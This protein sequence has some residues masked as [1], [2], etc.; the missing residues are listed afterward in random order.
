MKKYI[1]ILGAIF[2]VS[3]LASAICAADL[4]DNEVPGLNV[5]TDF[6]S[7]CNL[8]QNQN[9]SLVIIFDQD[10]CM[11]CD[12]FKNDVLSNA[13]IQKELNENFIVV[14]VDINKNPDI[15]NRYKIL[16]T[17]TVQFVKSNGDNATKIDGYVDSDEFLKA[18]KEI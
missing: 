13:S 17:P 7:A 11:Y 10:S 2:L 9:K 6:D 16:G 12:M 14:L 1:L 15:A 8:S 4:G 18:I 5:T 3:A